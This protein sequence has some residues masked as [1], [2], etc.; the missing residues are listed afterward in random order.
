M[1]L[2]FGKLPKKQIFDEFFLGQMNNSK[3]TIFMMNIKTKWKRRRKKKRKRLTKENDPSYISFVFTKN[4]SD[5]RVIVRFIY[6]PK[7][8][9]HVSQPS[10]RLEHFINFKNKKKK[11]RPFFV[12]LSTFLKWCVISKQLATYS[13]IYFACVWAGFVLLWLWLWH[14]FP[15]RWHWHMV[16]VATS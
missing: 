12:S 2:T 10:F 5:R 14:F 1:V 3:E 7:E 15:N 13:L 16:F 4:T 8:R 9:T 11:K 6:P